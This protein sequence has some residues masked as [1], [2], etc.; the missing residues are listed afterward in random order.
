M[1]SS[2]FENDLL[3]AHEPS[4]AEGRLR[5]RLGLRLRRELRFMESSLFEHDLLTDHEPMSED[6]R[7][8]PSPLPSPARGRG[9]KRPVGFEGLGSAGMERDGLRGEVR[10]CRRG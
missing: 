6:D 9:R 2:L 10:P 1:G 8:R 5:T 7:E 3:T 4:G